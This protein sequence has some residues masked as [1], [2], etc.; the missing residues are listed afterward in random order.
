[1]AAL[2]VAAAAGAAPQTDA[3]TSDYA[4]AL[5]AARA[6]SKPL[7]VVFHQPN[8]PEQAIQQVGYTQDNSATAMLEN[9]ELCQIDVSTE[10]GKRVAEAFRAKSFPYTVITDKTAKRVIYRKA[11]AFSD[12]QWITTLADYRKGVAPVTY[13]QQ[14]SV[15][16]DCPNCRK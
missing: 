10:N 14:G 1:M 3:W 2:I 16:G 13:V 15:V 9:Y 6:G 4:Q 7:L 5:D 11:G 12:S 8:Q